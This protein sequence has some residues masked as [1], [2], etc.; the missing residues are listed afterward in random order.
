[1]TNIPNNPKDG[2]GDGTKDKPPLDPELARLLQ[3]LR[4]KA[5]TTGRWYPTDQEISERQTRIERPPLTLVESK[6]PKVHPKSGAL[7]LALS[8]LPF[9]VLYFPLHLRLSFG[10]ALCYLICKNFYIPTRTR[11]SF[12]YTN[13][14]INQLSTYMQVCQGHLIRCLDVETRQE[15]QRMGTGPRTV[16]TYLAQLLEVGLVIPVSHGRPGKGTSRRLVSRNEQERRRNLALARRVCQDLH[17]P[18][19]HLRPRR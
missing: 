8:K 3:D 6:R 1:M 10:C 11:E 2:N 4:A 15:A 9:T 14:G 16:Q 13:L 5:E 7:E 12:L 19:Q 18:H 17:R